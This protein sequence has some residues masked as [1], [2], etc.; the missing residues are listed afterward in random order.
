MALQL[1]QMP[2]LPIPTG[3]ILMVKVNEFIP[4][5]GHEYDK[6]N[7]NSLS[8]LRAVMHDTRLPVQVRLEAANKLA[9]YEYPVPKPIPA[10]P[11]AGPGALRAPPLPRA[12]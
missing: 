8:F 7:H 3:E 1:R 11:G 2:Q 12:N 5:D 4:P 6:P 10:S 9:P